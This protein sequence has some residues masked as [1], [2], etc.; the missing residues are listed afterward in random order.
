MIEGKTSAPEASWSDLLAAAQ[1][2]DG[3][4]YHRFLTQIIPFVRALA[5]RRVSSHDSV[6]DIVQDVLL[7]VHRVR[8]TYEPGRPV[9]PW[10]AA[11][12][13]RRSI[14]ALRKSAR[15]GAREVHDPGA[16]ETF[17]DPAANTTETAEPARM[18]ERLVGGL[19]ARQRE[20]L[21]LTKLKEMSL[22]EASAASGQSLSSI[23]VNVHRA[24]KRLRLQSGEDM[25][26]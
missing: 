26:P 16:Y 6:E 4:A 15:T 7:T 2:G 5:R 1:A 14:D 17:A 10:L 8:H 21:E 13:S 20:A 18:L 19:P 23:K 22:S 3:D 25:R 12:T 11:I 9:Q 24:I